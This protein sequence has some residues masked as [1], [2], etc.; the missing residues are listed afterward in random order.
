MGLACIIEE[1]ERK[2]EELSKMAWERGIWKIKFSN[3]LIQ[4]HN[5]LIVIP[6]I[7]KNWIF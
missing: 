3:L 7:Y 6:K 5:L 1:E 2:E 4:I